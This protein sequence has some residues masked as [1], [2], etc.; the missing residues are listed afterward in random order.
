MGSHIDPNTNLLPLKWAYTCKFD[1]DGYL[2]SFKAGLVARGDLQKTTDKTYSSTSV[3]QV[4]RA[5]MAIAAVYKYKIRQYE[6]VAG[7]TNAYLTCPVVAHFPEGF[8]D[9]GCLLL[10]KKV[11]YGLS[12][13]ALIL[14]KEL[15]VTLIDMKL[16]QVPDINCLCKNN[17]LMVFIYPTKLLCNI[18]RGAVRKPI[19]SKPF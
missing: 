19:S 6:I 15:R 18:I 12:E 16:S 13:S 10:I 7:Y 17:H 5:T 11:F 3:T 9:Q 8:K 14:Q 1:I 2:L 4:F